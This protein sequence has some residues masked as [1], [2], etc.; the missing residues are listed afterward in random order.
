MRIKARR[1]KVLL[2]RMLLAR[3]LLVKVALASRVK[4]ALVA[5][6]PL[7]VKGRRRCL[8]RERWKSQSSSRCLMP[9]CSWMLVLWWTPGL[10]RSGPRPAPTVIT[11]DAGQRQT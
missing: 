4:R 11:L 3:M 1:D 8:M 9:G 2:A 7:V 6:R 5:L 10:E